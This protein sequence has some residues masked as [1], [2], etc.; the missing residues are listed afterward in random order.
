M[1]RGWKNFDEHDRKILDFLEQTVSRNMDIK[2]S[3][4]EGSEKGREMVEKTYIVLENIQVII[5]KLLVKLQLL[6]ELPMSSK[7]SEALFII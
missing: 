4:S 7:V 1:G 6:K 2:D 5:N 3:A